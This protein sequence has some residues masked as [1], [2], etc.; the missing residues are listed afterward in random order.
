L[1]TQLLAFSRKQTPQP[2]VVN[3]NSV[4][5]E[6][7]KLLRPMLGEDIDRAVVLA[8]DLGQVK[9]DAGQI[10]QVLMNLAVNARDAMSQGGKLIIETAN[11]EVDEGT[12]GGDIPV[13]PGRYVLMIVRDTGTGMDEET[14][15]RIFEPFY[16]TKTAE[17]GTGLGLATVYA[18][19][20]QAGG[21]ILV[22]TGLG[23]G[24]TFTIYL[25]RVDEVAEVLA[26][27]T[28]PTKRERSFG[29]ILL[30]EDELG[31]RSVIDE[32]LRQE[33]YTVLLAENGM[34]ALDVAAKYQ[35]PIQLL[36]TDVIMP[37][38]SGPQLAQSLKALRPETRVL[39]ISGYTADKFADY[40][41]LDPELALLQKPFKLVDLWQKVRDV[42]NGESVSAK[43]TVVRS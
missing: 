31:L 2:R 34:D 22:D 30:V 38:V 1:T 25:P 7:E 43:Q 37:S 36:I 3:L 11:A 24:T 12:I 42:L 20:E 6:T 29:T 18:I 5:K 32:S 27:Q 28:A 17:K 16:T 4:V 14:K 23:N 35:E 33:G 13:R 26:A 8:P 19:V 40:P 10:V 15:A 41:E 21:S 9:V 39:Y